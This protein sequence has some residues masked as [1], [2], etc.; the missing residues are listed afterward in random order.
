MP[1]R[2]SADAF[3]RLSTELNAVLADYDERDQ[4]MALVAALAEREDLADVVRLLVR[5]YDEVIDKRDDDVEPGE[6]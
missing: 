6:Q 3:D 4:V 2:P 5:Y 1:D